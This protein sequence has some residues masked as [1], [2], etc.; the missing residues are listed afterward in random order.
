MTENPTRP[1][2]F[3]DELDPIV[4]DPLRDLVS[5]QPEDSHLRA[6]L[7][8]I[9]RQS[10]AMEFVAARRSAP[11][12]RSVLA[13]AA[14]LLLILWFGAQT[15]AWGQVAQEFQRSAVAAT[16]DQPAITP[17]KE[18]SALLRFVLIVHVFS[19]LGGMFGLMIVWMRSL[20]DWLRAIWRPTLVPHRTGKIHV[21]ALSLYGLGIALGSCWSQ[22]TFGTFWRWDPREAF[23]LLTLCVGSV[24]YLSAD[25][26]QGNAVLQIIRR[27]VI[28]SI[29]FGLVMLMHG[30]AIPYSHRNPSTGFGFPSVV[31]ILLAANL[32][33]VLASGWWLACRRRSSV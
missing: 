26:S 23:A 13:A 9:G 22:V 8:R 32:T 10:P 19:L 16:S 33:V 29:S 21:V 27:T 14:C 4:L 20:W 15:K 17:P 11:R 7:E 30:L 18:V 6:S 1:L 25:A 24:W 5:L 28:A 31:L 12:G 3:A 2:F